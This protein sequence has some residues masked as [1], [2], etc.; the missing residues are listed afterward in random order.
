MRKS[1]VRY[2]IRRKVIARDKHK[3]RFCLS[4]LNLKV[5]HLT[6]VTLGGKDTLSNLITLCQ[7]CHDFFHYKKQNFQYRHL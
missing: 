3:C 1:G 2:N 4:E 7:K 6:P 5:H